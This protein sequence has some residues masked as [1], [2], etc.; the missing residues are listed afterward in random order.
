MRTRRIIRATL[1]TLLAASA[2]RK[3]ESPPPPP[4]PTTAMAP[5]PPPA[6]RPLVVE[7]GGALPWEPVPLLG[8]A[9]DALVAQLPLDG[10]GRVRVPLADCALATDGPAERRTPVTLTVDAAGIVV[11]YELTIGGCSV[12]A[13]DA[14]KTS[15][16]SALGLAEPGEHGWCYPNGVC[17]TADREA[18]GWRVR[19]VAATK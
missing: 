14:I 9:R 12:E 10:E 6:A 11:G 7:P 8:V 16:D 1:C 18:A 15:L 19:R 2:C 17:L 3:D 5:A 4:P 13:R